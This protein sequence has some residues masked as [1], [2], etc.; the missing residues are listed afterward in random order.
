MWER[1][2]IWNMKSNETLQP[3]KEMPLG[4]DSRD[5][6][7]CEQHREGELGIFVFSSTEAN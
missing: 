4:G 1:F 5:L 7:S 2:C 6:F 3:G